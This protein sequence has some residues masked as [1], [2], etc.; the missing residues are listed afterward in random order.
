M[1]G[2]RIVHL[3]KDKETVERIAREIYEEGFHYI[4]NKANKNKSIEN[5]TMFAIDGEEQNIIFLN[6]LGYITV[7]K[8]GSGCISLN[9]MKFLRDKGYHFVMA[10][11]TE[12]VPK[13]IYPV[14]EES[15]FTKEH[16]YCYAN[17]DGIYTLDYAETIQ[18]RDEYEK[19]FF[20]PNE[21]INFRVFEG[22]EMEKYLRAEDQRGFKPWVSDCGFSTY[23]GMHYLNSGLEFYDEGHYW[24]CA[25]VGNTIVGCIQYGFWPDEGLVM[26]YIDVSIPYR[27]KGIMK[28]MITKLNEYI[29][30]LET[31]SITMESQ[32]G[33]TIHVFDHFKKLMRCNIISAT[34]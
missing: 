33:K 13:G 22:K 34:Y 18:F 21:K 9:Q 29:P 7:A 1:K 20:P 27:N 8:S 17:Y 5:G 19:F 26:S 32:M 25:M 11:F 28:A 24:L 12:S 30:E 14:C 15:S 31:L 6:K 4:W 3:T 16:H 23:C 10:Y 2:L